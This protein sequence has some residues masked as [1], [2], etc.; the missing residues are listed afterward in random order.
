MTTFSTALEA[1]ETLE[2]SASTGAPT[3]H[4]LAAMCDGVLKRVR[5]LARWVLDL[6]TVSE[7]LDRVAP[8]TGLWPD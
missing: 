6:E 2:S 5:G 1:E 8:G 4:L 3:G 7:A